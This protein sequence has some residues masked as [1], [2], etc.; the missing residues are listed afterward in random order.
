MKGIYLHTLFP[1][2]LA[3][4]TRLAVPNVGQP[5]KPSKDC[6]L[7]PTGHSPTNAA[8]PRKGT[9]PRFKR[10]SGTERETRLDSYSMKCS[11]HVSGATDNR[12]WSARR[13]IRLRTSIT[14][15]SYTHYTCHE[16]H[17]RSDYKC[18]GVYSFLCRT[19]TSVTIVL[20][21]TCSL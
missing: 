3:S 6:C 14:T 12:V 2:R 8:G 18:V 11:R 21:S 13:G 10:F 1:N 4:D 16:C 20:Y 17:F 19:S 15:L 7:S 5:A 9:K